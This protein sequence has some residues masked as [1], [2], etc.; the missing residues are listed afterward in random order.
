VRSPAH[1]PPFFAVPPRSASS[2]KKPRAG[3]LPGAP[4]TNVRMF[5]RA[6]S[7]TLVL[8]R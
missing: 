7:A 5:T 1:A 3:S 6:A 8:S 2:D 4:I